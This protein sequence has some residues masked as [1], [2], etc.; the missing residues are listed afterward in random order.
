MSDPVTRILMIDDDE[1]DYVIVRRL[2]AK[3]ASPPC[4]IEWCGVFEPGLALVEERR[5]DLYVVDYQLGPRDG[6]EF[7]RAAA[8]QGSTG[9]FILLTA[10]ED[11]DLES[12]A[13]DAGVVDYLVKGQISAPALRR[14]IRYS[15]ARHE[16][17]EVLRRNDQEKTVLLREIHH[18]V[19]NNLQIISSLIS[20]QAAQVRD[21]ASLS[22]LRDAQ[23]RVH[24]IALIHERLY[25]APNLAGVDM[26]EYARGLVPLL[27]HTLGASVAGARIDVRCE[28]VTL[29][30]NTAVPCGLMISE[31]LTNALKHA[32]PSSGA[33]PPS[34][35]VSM[36]AK[37][38]I[39][40][41]SVTDNGVGLPDEV[42]VAK[43]TSIGIQLLRV[44]ARQLRG[45]VEISREE[46]TRVT[47]SFP[48][49]SVT[50]SAP[51]T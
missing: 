38:G 46:G 44:L 9:P 21:P 1:D 40:R 15:L 7:V 26:G 20:F 24:S 36:E 43:T 22:L 11:T 35:L 10:H 17:L 18:R 45:T 19:K 4:T 39:C 49:P 42:D 8:S 32:F 50:P 29:D 14:A 5:H 13:A 47:V 16:T 3:I 12:A 31:L 30:I 27:G 48:L 23:S 25:Q 2:V 28:E 34:I 51:A 41:L 37:D 6:I 33:R